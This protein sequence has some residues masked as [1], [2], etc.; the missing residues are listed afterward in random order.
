MK[1]TNLITH[2]DITEI[3]YYFLDREQ[4]KLFLE[5]INDELA[6][7]IGED[8]LLRL[9]SD[10]RAIAFALPFDEIYDFFERNIPNMQSTVS[11]IKVDYLAELKEKRKQILTLGAAVF[12]FC[13]DAG[14]SV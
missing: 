7:R 12:K 11:Q 14:D 13:S 10:N 8:L 9:S 4:E 3:G 6:E 2:S 5:S 1:T